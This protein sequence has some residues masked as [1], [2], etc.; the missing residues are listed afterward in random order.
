MTD[1]MLLWENPLLFEKLFAEHDIKCQRIS[2]ESIGTPFLPPCRCLVVPTGFANQ[3]YT[4]IL[5]GLVRNKKQIA[6][7][8]EKGGT[9][10][11][12]GPMVDGHEFNWLP[13]ELKYVQKQMSSDVLKTNEH[14]IQCI[15]DELDQVEFDGYFTDVQ[16]EV[17]LT[18]KDRNALMVSKK[19]GEG[20]IIA[21]TIHEFPCGNFLKWMVERSKSTRL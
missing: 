2:A 21:T 16:G 7:F 4:K 12:F 9:V 6:K 1:V 8:V 17:L 20:M 18:D 14:N 19:I 3:N 13:M 5:N 11:I 15:V 10:L